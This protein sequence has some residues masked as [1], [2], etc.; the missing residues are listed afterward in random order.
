MKDVLYKLSVSKHR[1][2]PGYEE[3]VGASMRELSRLAD[4]EWAPECLLDFVDL[5]CQCRLRHMQCERGTR[6]VKR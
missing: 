4:E 5:L 3:P 1:A 6:E 2:S